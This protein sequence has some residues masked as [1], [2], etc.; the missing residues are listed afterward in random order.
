MT[1]DGSCGKKSQKWSNDNWSPTAGSFTVELKSN[2]HLAL[3]QQNMRVTLSSFP[4]SLGDGSAEM[5]TRNCKFQPQV[6]HWPSDVYWI[7]FLFSSMLE[8]SSLAGN[9]NWELS[10]LISLAPCLW[11]KVLS[12]TLLPGICW[13]PAWVGLCPVLMCGFML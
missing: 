4:C 3:W 7:K 8:S 10:Y 6:F 2:H 9:L 12:P 1:W 13:M 5:L 11:Q